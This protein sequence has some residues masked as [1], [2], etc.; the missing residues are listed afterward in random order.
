MT[1]D[2]NEQI[3]G[4]QSVKSHKMKNKILKTI[5]ALSIVATSTIDCIAQ[6]FFNGCPGPKLTQFDTYLN[7]NDKEFSGM[8]IVKAFPAIANNKKALL[9]LPIGVSKNG[10]DIK[11][12]NVGYMGQ[13]IL[14]QE[15]YGTLALGVF[16]D[17]TGYLKNIVPQ[18]YFT[19]IK[20]GFTVDLEA[21]VNLN[22]KHKIGMLTLGYGNDRIRV[23]GSVIFEDGKKPQYQGNVRVDLKKDHQF[24]LQ[25]YIGKQKAGVRFVANF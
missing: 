5:I 16:K 14:N 25:G 7:Y 3:N 19:G 10:F 9:A 20:N 13:K 21:N 12:I 11:G 22:N 24:W 4:I 1:K 2:N 8:H 17:E 15:I 18:V 6:D 23:G